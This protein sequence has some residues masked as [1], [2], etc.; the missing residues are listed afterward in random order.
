MTVEEEIAAQKTEISA[1]IKAVAERDA[2]IIALRNSTSW[3][4]TAPLRFVTHQFRRVKRLIQLLLP[5]IRHSGGL[6]VAFRKAIRLYQNEGLQGIKRGFRVVSA[7]RTLPTKK[8]ISPIYRQ[9]VSRPIDEILSPRVLIIAEMSI[10]QCKKYRVQQ[11]QDMFKQLGIDCTAFAWTETAACLEAIQTHTLVIFYRVP[12]FQN[13]ICMIDEARRLC[14]PTIWEVDDF[15][16]EKEILV[17]SKTLAALDKTTFNQ[18]LDGAALYRNAM[19][20]CDRGIAS[21]EGLA[22]EMRRAGLPRVDVIENALDFQTLLTAEKVRREQRSRPD[23]IIRIVYGSGS[24]T[25]NIDFQEAVPALLAVLEKFP[26]VYL[27]IIGALDIPK[28]FD[29]YEAQLERVA[30]CTY[31][32]YL[33][34][35]AECDI[36]IAPLED[37]IFNESKSNIKYIEAAIVK[38]PSVCSPRAAFSQVIIH[39]ENGYLCE[40]DEQWELAFTR[41]VTDHAKRAQM[42]ESAYAHV[43]HHYAAENI[44]H[45]Q[46]TQL[47]THSVNKPNT[48]RILSVNC[49][50]SPRSFGGATIVAE[51]VNKRIHAQQ[52]FDVH[53][54]TALPSSVAAPYTTLRYEVDGLNVYGVGLPDYL[55]EKTK[56]ENPEIVTAFSN[57]LAAVQPDIVHFHSIQGIGVSVVDLCIQKGINYVVTLHDAWWLCGRQFMINKQGLFC[58]Q[59]KI[60]ANVCSKCVDNTSLNEIRNQRLNF[61]LK[62]ASALLAPSQFFA[63]FHAA[64]GWTNVR[65]NKN[66]VLKPNT[67]QRH[68]RIG[69]LRF[70]YVG[71]NTEI[72][73]FHLV[74]K[75]FSELVEYDIQLVLVDN[76]L[77]LGFSSYHQDDLAGIKNVKIVPA[78]TQKTIDDFFSSIDVLLFPTQSKESFGLTVREALARNVW[79]ISTDAG[80]AIEDIVP[81]QNGYIIPIFDT[82]DL[83]KQAIIDTEAHFQRIKVGQPITLSATNITFFEDQVE[84]LITVFKQVANPSLLQ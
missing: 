31:E 49:Y 84:D 51:E 63:N 40:T 56:F 62:N 36:S 9:V 8:D 14:I 74:K 73:G 44:A 45:Q 67:I 28:S 60:D 26:N 47:L 15:I 6:G 38:V 54:L 78:Y 21:T 57:V 83:L 3:R 66:G 79:V 10:P 50:Y 48:L 23:N 75:V 43:M 17:G 82:G 25:H 1:F 34:S 65:V 29:I 18:I 13:V 81:S 22:K 32:E 72:K 41:L 55:E 58:N 52:G 5:A 35:L 70:G 20:L 33:A 42:G 7:A 64:N 30:M 27:R 19:L 46:V 11:K 4:I 24:N 77:N 39:D 80:G 68:R 71:G 12:A 76:A 61:V 53:V 37:Y 2:Q 59:M 16:F 69:S